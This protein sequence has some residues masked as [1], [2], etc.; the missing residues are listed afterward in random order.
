MGRFRLDSGPG[1]RVTTIGV[2]FSI[3]PGSKSPAWESDVLVP[4]RQRSDERRPTVQATAGQQVSNCTGGV[5]E[6]SVALAGRAAPNPSPAAAYRGQVINA[7]VEGAV[8]KDP[9]LGGRLWMSRS[10]ENGPD[11]DDVVTRDRLNVTTSGQWQ[12]H[13]DGYSPLFGNEAG[14]FT[15]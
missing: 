7:A 11:F 8:G 4:L 6:I 1:Q 3:E 10:G 13:L 5:I 14:L 9:V 15:Q 2:G 12:K